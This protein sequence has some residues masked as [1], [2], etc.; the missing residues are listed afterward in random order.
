MYLPRLFAIQTSLRVYTKA[1]YSKDLQW[2]KP[3]EN[4]SQHVM[5]IRTEVLGAIRPQAGLFPPY[6]HWII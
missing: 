3:T 2:E 6:T 4:A 1:V 5:R